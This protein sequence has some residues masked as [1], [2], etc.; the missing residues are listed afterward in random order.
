[1]WFVSFVSQN[2]NTKIFFCFFLTFLLSSTVGGNQVARRLSTLHLD[3]R[4]RVATS[5]HR[6][7]RQRRQRVGDEVRRGGRLSHS[8]VVVDVAVGV[9]VSGAAVAAASET[10]KHKRAHKRATNSTRLIH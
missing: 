7:R 8:R 5:V 3:R 6:Q 9:A 2:V 10:R 1:M 4:R